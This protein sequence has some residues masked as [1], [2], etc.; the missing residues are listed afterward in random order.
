MTLNGVMAVISSYFIEFGIFEANCVT[1]VEVIP[2]LY[3]KMY[4]KEYSFGTVRLTVIL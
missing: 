1:V 3:D 4:P 2:I